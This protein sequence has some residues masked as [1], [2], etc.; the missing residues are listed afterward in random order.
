MDWNSKRNMLGRSRKIS[1]HLREKFQ[2]EPYRREPAARVTVFKPALHTSLKTVWLLD[3]VSASNLI[4]FLLM[5]CSSF[6]LYEY[7]Y[8]CAIHN[9]CNL[10]GQ[11]YSN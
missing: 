6:D 8:H 3:P 10:P 1:W 11:T 9:T 7:K 2:S 5:D 4:Y